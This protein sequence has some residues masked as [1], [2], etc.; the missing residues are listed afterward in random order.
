M[1]TKEE[2][3]ESKLKKNIF[4]SDKEECF[5]FYQGAGCPKTIDSNDIP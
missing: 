5:A 3:F 2:L 1:I 4:R